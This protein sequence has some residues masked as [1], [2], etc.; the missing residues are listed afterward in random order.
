M[1]ERLRALPKVQTLLE[2]E[3][4][5]D[6]INVYGYD[7]VAGAVRDRLQIVRD[8]IIANDHDVSISETA[9][10]NGA[11]A[12]LKASRR[13]SL[14]TAINATGII[15]HTNLGRARLAP[16]A[17]AAI[18][19]VAASYSNLEFDLATGKRGSRH[20]HVEQLICQL[21]S[22]EAAIVVNNCA[23]AI[24]SVL[25]AL[26]EGT[27]VIASRGEM[28]EI[29][30]S[31]RMPDVIAQ[32]GAILREVGTT[33]KT[34]L[35]D[36]ENAICD[37]TTVLLK[38]HT[39]NYAVVG[40]T[41]VPDRRALAELAAQTG[42]AFVEDLGSGVLVDLAPYGLPDEPVVRN[43][44][45]DGVDVVTF[46]GDKLLGGP[47]AGIIAGR[48][49]LIER[50]RKHPITRAVRIDK[51]S[52]AALIA[53]LDLYRAPNNPFERVPVLQSLSEPA[54]AI[55]TR[56]NRL[57]AALEAVPDLEARIVPSTAR[58]G[59]GAL[60]QQDLPSHAVALVSERWSPDDLA[61]AL[62]RAPVP[63]IGRISKETFLL[64]MRA[65][66]DAD[67]QQTAQ[68]VITAL[69]Q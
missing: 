20:D 8:Q 66:S 33:N 1:Q 62:R 26:G 56:A 64:D 47:Q 11:D 15:I 28:V 3:R 68:S 42:T 40:F 36:Y 2:S 55:E 54:H 21:T 14:Q 35:S 16:E 67:V 4:A 17:I 61:T 27:P 43:V 46:S 30:G 31:F 50:V 45:G 51:L 38:S 5:T 6:L 39:S 60:P 52:L 58:A 32:S 9:L 49:G 44:L 59:G 63:V 29:G 10:L 25:T 65:V 19:E 37:E 41:S 18:S 34:H 53:T 13:I 23:A 48:K 7:D 22:A 69:A 57:S 12:D 24:L